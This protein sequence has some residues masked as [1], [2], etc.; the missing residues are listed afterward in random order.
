MPRYLT[1][2]ELTQQGIE[3]VK[4]SP[5]RFRGAAERARSQGGEILGAWYTQG[6]YDLVVVSEW[7]DEEAGAAFA[8]SI[9]ATG[10]VRSVTMRAW[11]P[12]EFAGLVGRI[13]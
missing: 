11:T 12:D 3:N 9:A 6:P 10:N 1:L 4:Q 13:G 2:Y 8:L 5:E 7:D